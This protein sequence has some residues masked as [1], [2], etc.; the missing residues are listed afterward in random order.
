MAA[1]KQQ[2]SMSVRIVSPNLS[3]LRLV[4]VHGIRSEE[5]RKESTKF[6]LAAF[7]LRFYFAPMQHSVKFGRL[8][9]TNLP[10]L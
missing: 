7:H 2:W 4:I 8:R 1:N 3:L 6:S 10:H 5:L 9:Q